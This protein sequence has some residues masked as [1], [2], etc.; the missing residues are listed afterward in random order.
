M[1]GNSS[2]PFTPESLTLTVWGSDN[3]ILKE[4]LADAIRASYV[5]EANDTISIYTLSNSWLCTWELAMKKKARSKDSVVLD[6]DVLEILLGDA[7]KFLN[8][9]PWYA[10]KGIPYRRGYLLHG[11]PGCG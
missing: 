6:V 7:T 9:G 11:P 4:L 1:G 3:T 2:K 10:D 5:A 8:S